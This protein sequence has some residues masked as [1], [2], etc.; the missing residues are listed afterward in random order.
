MIELV[1]FHN[2][3]VKVCYQLSLKIVKFS[4][5]NVYCVFQIAIKI[6]VNIT[7]IFF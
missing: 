2:E 1:N 6:L 5:K 3:V 7:K 4:L